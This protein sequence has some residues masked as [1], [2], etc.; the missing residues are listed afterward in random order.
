ME[1]LAKKTATNRSPTFRNI[2][3]TAASKYQQQQLNEQTN[4]QKA[5]AQHIERAKKY[6]WCC[7]PKHTHAR[8]LSDS[9]EFFCM[10][11]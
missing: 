7:C 5:T 10:F 11:A 2:P 3:E 4:K 9:A 1:L 6:L 8:T